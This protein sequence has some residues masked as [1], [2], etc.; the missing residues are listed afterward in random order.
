MKKT[1]FK[2]CAVSAVALLLAAAGKNSDKLAKIKARIL[3]CMPQG[4]D[5]AIEKQL[6]TDLHGLL[7]KM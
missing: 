2:I 6:C 7:N 1:F 3:C 5:Q 4:V